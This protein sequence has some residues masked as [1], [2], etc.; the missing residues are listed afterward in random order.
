MW[1][2]DVPQPE[3]QAALNGV[4]DAVNASGQR[5]DIIALG[6]RQWSEGA[7]SSADW[8]VQ[9]A[10]RRQREVRNNIHFCNDCTGDLRKLR[11]H[12]KPLP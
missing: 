7:Y 6:S 5:R 2:Y 11:D 8:Y 1:S 9:E 4:V 3:A 12:Y 10:A